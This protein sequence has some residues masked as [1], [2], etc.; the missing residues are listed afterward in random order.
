MNVA[1][2][3]I[4]ASIKQIKAALTSVPVDYWQ[5]LAVSVVGSM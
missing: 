5:Q 4:A 1:V 2:S 3:L